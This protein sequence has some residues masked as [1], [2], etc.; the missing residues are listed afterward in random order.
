MAA[1]AKETPGSMAAILGLADEVV[2]YLC[3]K[4][5]NVWPANYN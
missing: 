2:E 1:A 4:I 3:K 5:H